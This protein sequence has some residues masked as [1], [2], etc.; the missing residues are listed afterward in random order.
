M[1]D[2]P[3]ETLVPARIR[4]AHPGLRDRFFARS[5]ARPMGAGLD[6]L[7][8]RKDGS[9]VPVEIL[10]SRSGRRWAR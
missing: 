1:I 9:E 6:L 10:L 3:V 7:A 8:V 2:Q 5:M 4:D